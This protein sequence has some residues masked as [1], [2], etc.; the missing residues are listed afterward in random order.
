MVDGLVNKGI[1]MKTNRSEILTEV[2]AKAGGIRRLS[3]KLN[4]SFQAVA[5]WWRVPV[6]H[7]QRVSVITGIPAEKIRPDIYE[8]PDS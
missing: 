6:N 2:L 7:V 3:V 8:R 4:I 5:K 1:A